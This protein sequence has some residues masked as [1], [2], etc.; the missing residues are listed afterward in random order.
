MPRHTQH[1][2]DLNKLL[3]LAEKAPL[4]RKGRV[5]GLYEQMPWPVIKLLRDKGYSWQEV[6]AW[7][8]K[9]TGAAW[10]A[11]QLCSGWNVRKRTGKG[12]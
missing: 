9:Y 6:S 12:K 2:A 5:S 10:K 8:Q 11:S 3:A 4:G 1:V 7:L